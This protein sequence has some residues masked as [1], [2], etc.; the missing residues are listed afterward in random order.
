MCIRKW[1]V[2]TVLSG[3]GGIGKR[4]KIEKSETEILKNC[5]L[6]YKP[7]ALDLEFILLPFKIC[8]PYTC[9]TQM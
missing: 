9:H 1:Y 6:T 7:V 5:V 8:I 4:N 3:R 2:R